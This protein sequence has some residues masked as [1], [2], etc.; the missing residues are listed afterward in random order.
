MKIS[1]K[2]II[3][4]L[5][6]LALAAA[7]TGIYLHNKNKSRMGGNGQCNSNYTGAC[8]PNVSYDINCKD[9]KHRVNVVGKDVYHFDADHDG[10]GCEK[11]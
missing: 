11:Y 3:W 9:I 4:A 2:Q 1:K 5:V 8:V 10:V 6:I 7:L